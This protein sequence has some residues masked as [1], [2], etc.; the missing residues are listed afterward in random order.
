MVTN[1]VKPMQSA[2]NSNMPTVSSISSMND[3]S[4]QVI[5][6]HNHF[7][8]KVPTNYHSQCVEH[9]THI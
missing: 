8:E 1:A 4:E 2:T 7:I 6:K 3:A 9:M 5:S